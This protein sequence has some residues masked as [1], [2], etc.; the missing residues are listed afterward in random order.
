MGQGL[1]NLQAKRPD[2]FKKHT[3]N[4]TDLVIFSC[5]MVCG[6]RIY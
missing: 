5:S 6:F 4:L 2:P 3:N 1:N